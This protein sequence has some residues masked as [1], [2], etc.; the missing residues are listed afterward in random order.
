[1]HKENKAMIIMSEERQNKTQC[2]PSESLWFLPAVSQ[3]TPQKQTGEED[4]CLKLCCHQHSLCAAEAQGQ[5]NISSS[6]LVMEGLWVMQ[7]EAEIL[8]LALKVP[9]GSVNSAIAKYL[10]WVAAFYLDFHGIK[11]TGLFRSH[12]CAPDPSHPW[13]KK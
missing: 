4:I 1:M 2:F 10:C 8:Q 6:L 5:P 11:S 7:Q 13:K 3:T 9:G 12:T